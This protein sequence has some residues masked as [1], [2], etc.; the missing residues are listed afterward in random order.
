MIRINVLCCG[1]IRKRDATWPWGGRT[2]AASRTQINEP[3]I[4]F[5]ILKKKKK[6]AHWKDWVSVRQQKRVWQVVCGG[7]SRLRFPAVT[8][9]YQKLLSV[10]VWHVSLQ[11]NVSGFVFTTSWNSNET[12]HDNQR[13]LIPCFDIWWRVIL[14]WNRGFIRFSVVFLIFFVRR[15]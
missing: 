7:E 3:L 6:K 9:V 14:K 8:D 5:L 15:N 2:R 11:Y 13:V 4:Y 10:L 1:I 12:W